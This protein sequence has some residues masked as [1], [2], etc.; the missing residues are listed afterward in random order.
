VTASAES[1]FTYHIGIVV[2]DID[3]TMACYRDLLQVPR[4]HTWEVE[5]VGLPTN[6]ATAGRRGRIRIA[7]GRAP[8]Q[9]IELLQP[10]EG[11]TIWSAFLRDHG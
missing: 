5:R 8:G 1:I 11:E 2:R 4:W 6:P 3:A 7:Y 10:L 9:T